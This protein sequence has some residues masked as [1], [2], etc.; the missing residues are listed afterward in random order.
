MHANLFNCS[1]DIAGITANTSG[2]I[3]FKKMAVESCTHIFSIEPV[4]RGA[5]LLAVFILMRQRAC[6]RS[7]HAH[8]SLSAAFIHLRSLEQPTSQPKITKIASG[9]G[10]RETALLRSSQKCPRILSFCSS[11]VL[12]LMADGMDRRIRMSS[13]DPSPTQF[14][15]NWS[16]PDKRCPC[17]LAPT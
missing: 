15:I 11:V 17:T 1:R 10:P 14:G 9:I 7:M 4:S 12:V 8:K 16:E 2:K 5:I 13:S 3:H 6:G